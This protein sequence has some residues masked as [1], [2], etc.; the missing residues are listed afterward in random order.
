LEREFDYLYL[1]SPI[2]ELQS[3]KYIPQVLSLLE[4][5]KK[6]QGS[7]RSYLWRIT[8]GFFENLAIKYRSLKMFEPLEAWL[9]QNKKTIGINW[10]KTVSFSFEIIH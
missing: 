6:L 4:L 10:L 5:S 8:L 9:S 2:L 1:A 3:P 7:G